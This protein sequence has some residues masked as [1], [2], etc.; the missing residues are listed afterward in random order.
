MGH[1]PAPECRNSPAAMPS[2]RRSTPAP[3]GTRPPAS[4]CSLHGRRSGPRPAAPMI[5]LTADGPGP[6]PASPS[7]LPPPRAA[8]RRCPRR[9]SGPRSPP[10]GCH[11]A[12]SVPSGA[13]SAG[14]SPSP[15]PGTATDPEPS[16]SGFPCPPAVPGKAALP[17]APAP[18]DMASGIAGSPASPA[19]RG[20]SGDTGRPRGLSGRRP[21]AAGYA[22]RR[23]LVRG[24]PHVP[25]APSSGRQARPGEGS[26]SRTASKLA[27]YARHGIVTIP[28]GALQLLLHR[29]R[30]DPE[31]SASAGHAGA[32]SLPRG[33]SCRQGRPGRRPLAPRAGVGASLLPFRVS[34]ARM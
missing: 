13:S 24:W 7:P 10:P 34:S 15:G 22:A 21:G 1:D 18:D 27:G 2:A 33:T 20:T 9:P 17:G 8:G 14:P 6:A 23:A 4:P 26:R 19:G 28:G 11:R 29:P 5:L 30:H 32:G 25:A 31:L 12:A 3:P 16:E